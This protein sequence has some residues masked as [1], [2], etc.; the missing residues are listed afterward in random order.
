MVVK[1]IIVGIAFAL[2]AIC[3]V[4]ATSA[5]LGTGGI[6]PP[7][8][9]SGSE[10]FTL[11][12]DFPQFDGEYA[13]YRSVPVSVTDEY[14]QEI[15]S[16]FGLKGTPERINPLAGEIELVDTTKT[17][18]ERI[19]VYKSSGAFLYDIPDKTYP[20][21]VDA[22]PVLPSDAE[23]EK[24]ARDYLSSKR[25]LPEDAQV[26]KIFVNQQQEVWEGG[27]DKPLKVFDITLAVRFNRNID[28]IPVYGDEFVVFIG[29]NSEVVGVLRNWRDITP[30]SAT[31]IKTAAEAYDELRGW[32]TILPEYQD[33]NDRIVINSISLGYWMEPRSYE[34]EYVLP[35]YVFRGVAIRDG[36]ENPYIQ[37]VYA[38]VPEDLEKFS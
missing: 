16:L 8:Q 13:V 19:T 31:R 37:Y 5:D 28:G 15:A 7:A 3:A 10:K 21:A 38:V 20:T 11:N 24:I 26:E 12:A 25:L 2:I 34:Q 35:V 1:K 23:A 33:V 14:V 29:N 32:K 4:L 22:Q 36:R 27:M 9:G 6:I 18:S 17:M 30:Y